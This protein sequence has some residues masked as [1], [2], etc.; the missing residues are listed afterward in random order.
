MHA[1]PCPPFPTSAE[2]LLGPL[3]AADLI[4]AE[5]VE[6]AKALLR[7]AQVHPLSALLRL[8]AVSEASLYQAYA[9]L[10]ALPLLGTDGTDAG[11]LALAVRRACTELGLSPD[12]LML[13]GLL[14]SEGEQAWQLAV[15]EEVRV[16]PR[17]GPCSS[18]GPRPDRCS[19]PR[20]VP[21]RPATAWRDFNPITLP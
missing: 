8:N 10:L 1:S 14:V 20:A 9:D 7:T 4:S 6:R 15:R 13:K 16:P 19:A 11:E 3:Q 5:S 18:A 17:H 2:N 21:D 12:W